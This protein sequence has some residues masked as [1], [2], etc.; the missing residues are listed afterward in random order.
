[1]DFYAM[2]LSPRKNDEKNK[3]REQQLNKIREHVITKEELMAELKPETK[4]EQTKE[5]EIETTE[6]TPKEIEADE[7][8]TGAQPE[9]KAVKNISPDFLNAKS[10]SLSSKDAENKDEYKSSEFRTERVSSSIKVGDETKKEVLKSAEKIDVKE[11]TDKSESLGNIPETN[12]SKLAA[13]T[14]EDIIRINESFIKAHEKP[15]KLKKPI[16]SIK[17]DPKVEEENVGHQASKPFEDKT[18]KPLE[19]AKAIEIAK[20]AEIKQ[21]VKI[22]NK[23]EIEQTKEIK[24]EAPIVAAQDQMESGKKKQAEQNPEENIIKGFADGIMADDQKRIEKAID[25]LISYRQE[26]PERLGSA[27]QFNA[28]IKEKL[29]GIIPALLAYR[30]GKSV[31]LV[32]QILDEL[33]I[34]F[35]AKDLAKLPDEILKSEEMKKICEKY[36]VWFAKFYPDFP[37]QLQDRIYYF[38]KC[39]IISYQEIKGFAGLQMAINTDLVNFIRNNVQDARDIER[40]IYEFALAGFINEKEF[41]RETK[42]RNLI[43]K[44]ISELI[45][46]KKE[47]P[48]ETARKIDEYEK[49]GLFKGSEILEDD[50]I[51][52]N[53]EKYLLR[54]KR[55]NHDHPRKVSALVKD[56]F[57][58]GLISK[59]LRDKILEQ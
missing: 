21:E 33:N 30:G 31:L 23:L 56:Y 53:I 22:E 52:K 37:G 38:N 13:P 54:Y 55:E 43:K 34:R 40:K 58:A 6:Q 20:P 26:D 17:V 29:I 32:F 2:Q 24:R 14:T 28:K 7:V 49:A 12:K 57:N 27:D 47:R 41:K 1:M 44:F 59:Q 48:L 46:A 4:E 11:G 35:V 3:R 42:V 15:V 18:V 5:I 10:F 8:D 19:V 16:I 51:E 45:V 50:K 25:S 39:G 9:S 36:L